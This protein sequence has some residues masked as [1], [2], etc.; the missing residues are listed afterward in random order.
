[1]RGGVLLVDVSAAC[2]SMPAGPIGPVAEGFPSGGGA[3]PVVR[4][5]ALRRPRE[6]E[7]RAQQTVD[8]GRQGRKPAG[9]PPGLKTSSVGCR[10]GCRIGC[11]NLT[12]PP[13]LSKNGHFGNSNRKLN[14][15]ARDNEFV[16]EYVGA[17]VW[18][19]ALPA[20]SSLFWP[21]YSHTHTLTYRRQSGSV[22]LARQIAIH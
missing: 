19:R 15:P 4:V 9:T 13:D 22:Q 12:T 11:R 7:E 20:A 8:R 10:I 14:A 21:T 1:M 2:V 18:E 17:W 6:Q 3:L 5:A 16:C